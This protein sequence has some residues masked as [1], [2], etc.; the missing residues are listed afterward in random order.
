MI[1]ELEKKKKKSIILGV[2]SASWQ[3]ETLPVF[4][5]KLQL[6]KQRLLC[7][8]NQDTREHHTSVYLKVDGLKQK[9]E[10]ESGETA[11]LPAILAPLLSAP[12]NPEA[13]VEVA[14]MALAPACGSSAHRSD[15]PGCGEGTHHPG[16]PRGNASDCS[17]TSSSKAPATP[18]AQ[19]AR[20]RRQRWWRVQ[21]VGSQT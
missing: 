1:E 14:P 9:K 17:N 13:E 12:E 21:S 4:P 5:F 7:P 2:T 11:L 3:H 15:N 6:V 8:T 20:M 18:E 10:P 16:V 19:A